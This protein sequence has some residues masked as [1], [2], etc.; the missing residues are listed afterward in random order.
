MVTSPFDCKRT[1]KSVLTE[2]RYSR[3]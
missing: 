3:F 1:V 2:M